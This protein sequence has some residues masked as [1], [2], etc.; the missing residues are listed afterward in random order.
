MNEGDVITHHTCNLVH[1]YTVTLSTRCQAEMQGAMN[2]VDAHT[3]ALC[4]YG[5][6]HRLRTRLNFGWRGVEGS[7]AY[8]SHGVSR[9]EEEG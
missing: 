2:E 8:Q 5:D 3:S 6:V 9:E 1:V 7:K 4:A